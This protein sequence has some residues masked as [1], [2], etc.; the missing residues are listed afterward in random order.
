VSAVTTCPRC[1]GE[2]PAGA[3]RCE[4]CGHALVAAGPPSAEATPAAAVPG[5]RRL[6]AGLGCGILAVM[7]VLLSIVV[8][9]GLLL[10]GLLG[11]AAART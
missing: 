9:F 7:L 6:I 4:E 2:L 10:G 5:A 8:L 1:G 3:T 11:S